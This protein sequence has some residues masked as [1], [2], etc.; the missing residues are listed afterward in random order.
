MN[1]K[2]ND[3][4]LEMMWVGGRRGKGKEVKRFVMCLIRLFSVFAG[5]VS[6]LHSC[7]DDDD[8]GDL[9]G[10]WNKFLSANVSLLQH[11]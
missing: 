9:A 3:K 7:V 6:K 8:A 1:F 4:S 10:M 2:K 5:S 11:H